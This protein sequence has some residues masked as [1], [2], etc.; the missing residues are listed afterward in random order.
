[1]PD[2]VLPQAP[3]SSRVWRLLALALIGPLLL[4]LAGCSPTEDDDDTNLP[5]VDVIPVEPDQRGAV[6]IQYVLRDQDGRFV[7]VLGD[8]LVGD[9]TPPLTRHP[10]S[11]TLDHQVA[12]SLGIVH[13]F[14]WNAFVDLGPGV[15]DDVV[16]RFTP[17]GRDGVG[18]QDFTFPFRVDNSDA[19]GE[20][21]TDARPSRTRGIGA[22]L[23]DSR[24][25]FGLGLD[26]TNTERADLFLYEPSFNLF[27]PAPSLPEA[28]VGAFAARLT[29]GDA[30]IAGGRSGGVLQGAAHIL[31]VEPGDLDGSLVSAGTL[32]QPREDAVMVGLDDGRALVI[33]GQ[34]DGGNVA[35]GEV[36]TGTGFAIAFNNSNFAR[37]GHTVTRLADG[38]LLVVGGRNTAGTVQSSCFTITPLA[39]GTFQIGIADSL[40]TA[41]AEHSALLLDDGR[42]AIV[43]GMGSSAALASIELYDPAMNTFTTSAQPLS[44]PRRR[45]A[46]LQDGPTLVAIGGLSTTGSPTRVADRLDLE[47]GTVE[48][49]RFAALRDR[50]LCQAFRF[51]GGRAV[52]L[53]GGAAPERFYPR[54][55]LTG[56]EDFR[57]YP[58]T[59]LPRADSVG[60][61]AGNEVFQ[62]G[63]TDGVSPMT[64][65]VQVMRITDSRFDLRGNLVMARTNHAVVP[66]LGNNFVRFVVAG[67]RTPS[68]VTGHTEI[69]DATTGTSLVVGALNVPREDHAMILLP[70]FR[71]L[72]LGGRDA[73]GNVL[74]SV[75][76][77][78]PDTQSWTMVGDLATARTE[79]S[80]IRI[81]GDTEVLIAG[82]RGATGQAL[83]SLEVYDVAEM[84]LRTLGATLTRGRIS[85]GLGFDIS[86]RF[87]AIIAG[88]DG[89]GGSSDLDVLSLDREA[90]E[91]TR[92]ISDRRGATVALR[93][94]DGEFLLYGGVAGEIPPMPERLILGDD[95]T[96]ATTARPNDRTP[97][98]NRV[99]AVA[100]TT[101]MA[102]IFVG[103]R[104]IRGE[105]IGGAEF[106]DPRD[107]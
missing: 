49:T 28:R 46:I 81:N 86:R 85:P 107:Q 43:G 3:R 59:P 69:W 72:A 44:D 61:L 98:I 23:S 105:V 5:F 35:I 27:I 102:P 88:D 24:L 96:N 74:S 9:D 6:E 18:P 11:E 106:F 79:M 90:I 15:F 95:P 80:V 87:L 54:E 68:G 16:L 65:A 101:G 63:G 17:L 48:P 76:L 14:V 36:F 60:L 64:S 92:P 25:I 71:V 104:S 20:L 30:L 33:G 56:D 12:N 50:G 100:V 40:N 47:Q 8:R 31:D 21:E 2:P 7:D 84:S 51:G 53:G 73:G 38:R 75:E 55:T 58:R 45:P 78:S 93:A 32:V 13:S 91:A 4:G 52:I 83:A 34:N 99:G 10:S 77:Y 94:I 41:R 1:M 89:T 26:D 67:G 82:G 103:G 29:G 19:F 39:N 97:I 42:V 70:R 66:H 57:T 22:Q 37:T 62:F